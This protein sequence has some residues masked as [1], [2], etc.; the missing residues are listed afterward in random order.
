MATTDYP[1]PHMTHAEKA[2]YA[3]AQA[4]RAKANQDAAKAAGDHGAADEAF[5]SWAYWSVEADTWQAAND[6]DFYTPDE[7]DTYIDDIDPWF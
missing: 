6:S 7:T 5:E 1:R 2:A 4:E 3:T